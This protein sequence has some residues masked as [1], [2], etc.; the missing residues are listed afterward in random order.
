MRRRPWIS[1]VHRWPV[2]DHRRRC[3]DRGALL[4][5]GR[6]DLLAAARADADRTVDLRRRLHRRPEVGLHLPETQAM[7]LEALAP[8]CRTR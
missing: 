3:R 6:M 5:T 4:K 7:V 1:W 8:T 2:L